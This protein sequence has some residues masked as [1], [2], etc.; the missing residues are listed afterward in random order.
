LHCGNNKLSTTAL[1]ALFGTLHSN[2]ISS[3]KTILIRDN[4]GEW[5][6]D[7]SIAENKGWDGM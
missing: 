5:D 6:C 3:G 7:I 2:T 1:N 4:P